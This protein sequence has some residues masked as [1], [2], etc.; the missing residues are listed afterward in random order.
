MFPFGK[1]Q[2]FLEFRIHEEG[3]GRQ[4]KL[5]LLFDGIALF[6]SKSGDRFDRNRTPGRQQR[7][8]QGAHSEGKD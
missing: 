3:R 1:Q 8:D 2:G 6:V 7:G 4:A 5:F